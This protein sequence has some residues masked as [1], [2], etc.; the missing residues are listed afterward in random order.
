MPTLKPLA[1]G[2]FLSFP[3]ESLLISRPVL[4][5]V[6]RMETRMAS[7]MAIQAPFP[8]TIPPLHLAATQAASPTVTLVASLVAFLVAIS[9]FP[10]VLLRPRKLSTFLS[11]LPALILLPVVIPQT[12]MSPAQK[13][14]PITAGLLPRLFSFPPSPPLLPLPFLPCLASRPSP[15]SRSTS[16]VPALAL[17]TLALAVTLRMTA[18]LPTGLPLLSPTTRTPL[19][20]LPLT[21]LAQSPLTQP[22]LTT[23]TPPMSHTA[24]PLQLIPRTLLLSQAPRFTG[25]RVTRLPAPKTLRASPSALTALMVPSTAVQAILVNKAVM[26]S[27]SAQVLK[28]RMGRLHLTR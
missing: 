11:T 1:M 28:S 6:V 15:L 24:D 9:L 20:L 14:P 8:T 26:L 13:R 7:P 23:R 25:L 2:K 4:P 17:T 19:A 3:F 16:G 12:R 5:A 27:L 10:L 18:T 21:T 22:R